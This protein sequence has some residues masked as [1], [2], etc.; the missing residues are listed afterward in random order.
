M[1]DYPL[2]ETARRAALLSSEG[3]DCYQ[4]FTCRG[5]KRR[6]TRKEPNL[7]LAMGH[8][9]YCGRS[10]DIGKFGCN[11]EIARSSDGAHRSA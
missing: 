10:T 11:Y 7:F 8:C 9:P 2:A 5:C 6:V 1:T 4:K 3:M